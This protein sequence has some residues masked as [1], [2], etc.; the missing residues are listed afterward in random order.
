MTITDEKNN[1]ATVFQRKVDSE[2]IV[3]QFEA[4]EGTVEI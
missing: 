4:K 1:V 3:I 2:P